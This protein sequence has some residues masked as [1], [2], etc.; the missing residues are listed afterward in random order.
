MMGS[1]HAVLVFCAFALVSLVIGYLFQLKSLRA[2]LA[3]VTIGAWSAAMA[4]A[5]HAA[6]WAKVEVTPEIPA[7]FGQALPLRDC[8][9][10]P[11]MTRIPGG[12]LR[13]EHSDGR[14]VSY[15]IWPG[16][17]ISERPVSRRSYAA[18]V[19]ETGRAYT[20]C[21]AGA[22]LDIPETCVSRDDAEAYAQWL[23]SK[24]SR[25][26]ELPSDVQWRHAVK[27]SKFQAG[28]EIS[29]AVPE[30]VGDCGGQC[31][32]RNAA[33]TGRPFRLMRRLSLSLN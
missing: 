15:K 9:V 17:L 30:L 3:Y 8:S 6:A 32:P 13:Y 16:F 24:S 18:F 23:I 27:A 7:E 19:K 21:T 29:P 1:V 22:G 12:T 11:A 5:V 10:C 20:D 33:T 2:S 14:V 4:F 26:Y 31:V 28:I 25:P